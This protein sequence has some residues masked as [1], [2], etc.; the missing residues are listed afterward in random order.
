MADIKKG[1]KAVYFA[2]TVGLG[3]SMIAELNFANE[4]KFEN[5][6]RILIFEDEA[7]FL[8]GAAPLQVAKYKTDGSQPIS[9]GDL[10]GGVKLMEYQGT[11]GGYDDPG[12]DP[13]TGVIGS[14]F[15][16]IGLFGDPEELTFRYDD[17]L[18][19]L[20]G[21]KNGNQD[22]KAKILGN[23]IL[24]DDGTSFIRVSDKSNPFD[25]D[26]KEYFEGLVSFDDLFKASAFAPGANSNKFGSTAFIHYF[27]NNNGVG[28]LGSAVYK[29]DG[30]Q[31]MQLSDQL[32]GATLVGYNG[33]EG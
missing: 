2:G 12:L 1:S 6:T 14:G 16:V 5:D 25:L 19:L 22:G 8:T 33:V 17:S 28:Y 21:G 11:R 18:D 26:G 32:A 10:I 30:S 13:L 15:S 9:I 23:R 29:T 3:Q 31:P 4:D 24:D 7:A 20:T 27:D